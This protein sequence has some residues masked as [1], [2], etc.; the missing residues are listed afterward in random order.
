MMISK[1]KVVSF[2]SVVVALL[3]VFG[4]VDLAISMALYNPDSM[5][6]LFFEAFGE[7]PGVLIAIFSLSALIITRNKEKAL[8]NWSSIIGFGILLLL[9]SI[10]GAMMPAGYIKGLKPMIPVF[11][12]GYV[13]LG[14]FLAY[15]VDKSHYEALRKAAIVG[16]L[17]F[18]L[19][20]LT[21]NLIKMGWGRL[22]FRSMIEPAQEY[23]RWFVRQGF[24]MD[25]ER[26]SF[27]S[28]HSANSAVIMW[29]SL[30]PT[31]IPSLQK[32]KKILWIGAGIWTVLVMVSRVIVGAHFASDVTMGAAIS[33]C[34][35]LLLTNWKFKI[36]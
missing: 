34:S 32:N 16:I 25:N 21:I 2:L 28:G 6:G 12:I 17:S 29:I 3:I 35:F 19:A 10:M 4:F 20:I 24:T 31:F 11:T 36:E 5:Y 30:L 18:V 33:I 23:T 7:L 13:V 14:L 9:F 15:Q 1:K 26:M 22:R 8:S 27:P